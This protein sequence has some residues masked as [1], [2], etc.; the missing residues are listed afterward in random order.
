MAAR[1]QG[2][3]AFVTG[4]GTGIG[5]ATAMRFAAEGATVVVCGRRQAPLD[6]VVAG[7]RAS[8]GKAEAVQ[9]DV[10]DEAAFVGAIE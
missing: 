2:K 8:G 7:I 5:A 6:E 10:S 4:G 1:L 3:V 9:A